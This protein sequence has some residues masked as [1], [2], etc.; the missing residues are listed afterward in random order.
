V[1]ATKLLYSFIPESG[2]QIKF[3]NFGGEASILEP[4]IKQALLEHMSEAAAQSNHFFLNKVLEDDRKEIFKPSPR[5]IN[6]A[7]LEMLSIN[8]MRKTNEGE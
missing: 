4:F 6:L 1:I 5:I 2:E 3:I 7:A 8:E